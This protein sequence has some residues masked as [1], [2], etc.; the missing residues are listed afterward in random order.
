MKYYIKAIIELPIFFFEFYFT[1]RY[2]NIKGSAMFSIKK[3]L[4]KDEH[5]KD[6]HARIFRFESKLITNR[7]LKE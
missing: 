2:R 7:F 5:R 4:T 6:L 1:K 3:T